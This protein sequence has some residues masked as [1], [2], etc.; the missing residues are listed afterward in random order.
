M[1]ERPPVL[2]AFL[3]SLHYLAANAHYELGRAYETFTEFSSAVSEYRSA[4]NYHFVV[5]D[6]LP[7]KRRS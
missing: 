4:V 6:S 1:A 3:D 7:S 2:Q 5:A